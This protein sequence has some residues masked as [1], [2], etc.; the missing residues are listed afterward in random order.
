MKSRT[1]YIIILIIA[2]ALLI[3]AAISLA[4]SERGAEQGGTG[5]G[6][7]SQQ[8]SGTGNGG[9]QSDDNQ[10]GGDNSAPPPIDGGL[11][12][13]AANPADD[14]PVEVF[15]R[16]A[17]G[18]GSGTNR[19]DKNQT[20]DSVNAQAKYEELGAYFIFPDDAGKIYLTFDLGYENGYTPVILDSLKAAGVKATFF[21]T[22]DYVNEAPDIVR[23]I[24]DEGHTLANHTDRHPSMPGITDARVRDEIM[25]LHERIKDEFGYTMTL[26][27]FPMGEYSEH[28]L[29]LVNKLG[30]K[31]IFWSFA[32]KDWLTDSQPDPASSLTKLTDSLHDGG[33]YLLHAVSSTNAEIMDDFLAEAKAKGFSFELVDVR[34]GLVKPAPNAPVETII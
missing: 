23:R 21:I 10:Q 2:A 32:Y 28:T 24:I 20:V 16:A 19:N 26:F 11:A 18:W 3:I 7:G 27:R 8:Q 22:S 13:D 4:S 9:T 1:L 12:D 15:S 14:V 33:I 31:S 30:Y 25:T 6:S 34:L 5:G 17:V 29:D